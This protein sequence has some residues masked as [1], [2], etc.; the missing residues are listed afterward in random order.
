MKSLTLCF[1]IV[2]KEYNEINKK[3]NNESVA[4]WHRNTMK[5]SIDIQLIV[6]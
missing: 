3:N 2:L 5:N 6:I 4:G 1:P